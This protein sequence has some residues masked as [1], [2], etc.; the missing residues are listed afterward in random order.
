MSKYLRILNR[1]IACYGTAVI[2]LLACGCNLSSRDMSPEDSTLVNFV[3]KDGFKGPFFLICDRRDT[4]S[5][6]QLTFEVSRSDVSSGNLPFTT[7]ILG[8][9]RW[10]SG[11]S[12]PLSIGGPPDADDKKVAVR[13]T[14]LE[15]LIDTEKSREWYVVGTKADLEAFWY[16]GPPRVSGP[17]AN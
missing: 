1:G 13:E 5:P 3:I 2:L 7:Y 16:S 12:M 17:G 11:R 4:R 9:A 6:K 8:T 10:K 14:G 15:E